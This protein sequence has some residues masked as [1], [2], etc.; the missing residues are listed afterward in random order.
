MGG[1]TSTFF[2]LKSRHRVPRVITE[3][4]GRRCWGWQRRAQAA[5]PAVSD[6]V[7]ECKREEPGGWIDLQVSAVTGLSTLVFLIRPPPA[8]PRDPFTLPRETVSVLISKSSGGFLAP[9]AVSCSTS[10]SCV[11]AGPVPALPPLLWSSW[12]WVV[13]GSCHLCSYLATVFPC[14]LFRS[15]PYC[16]LPPT[17]LF[18]VCSVRIQAHFSRNFS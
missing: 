16:R 5:G 1:S 14:S 10:L 7:W 9:G 6:H 18:T 12:S 15:G 11:M 3:K 8:G 17:W 2:D 13:S 4:A